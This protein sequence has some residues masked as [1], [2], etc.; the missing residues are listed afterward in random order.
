MLDRLKS[1]LG[2]DWLRLGQ[3]PAPAASSVLNPSVLTPTAQSAAAVSAGKYIAPGVSVG[4]TQGVS[5]PTSR[6]TVEVDLG[7]HIT[8][9]TEAGQNG[10][11]ASASITITIIEPGRRSLLREQ[12]AGVLLPSSSIAYFAREG[13]EE[14][15]NGDPRRR[16]GRICGAL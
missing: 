4:V 9:S 1:G 11:P 16:I 3:G 6:V 8:V 14:G 15:T 10:G 7:H 2:L 5:P 13:S 12:A